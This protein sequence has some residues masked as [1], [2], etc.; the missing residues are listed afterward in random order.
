MIGADSVFSWNNFTPGFPFCSNPP[1]S[2]WY[3]FTDCTEF[4]PGD[5][6]KGIA[7]AGGIPLYPSIVN[8]SGESSSPQWLR[9]TDI[10]IGQHSRSTAVTMWLT[11]NVLSMSHAGRVA[12]QILKYLQIGEKCFQVLSITRRDDDPGHLP[13]RE[14]KDS[15]LQ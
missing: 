7:D 13:I 5:Q 11:G 14:S 1:A 10:D 9:F 2:S 8:V 6:K 15:Y 3:L 4:H 12:V